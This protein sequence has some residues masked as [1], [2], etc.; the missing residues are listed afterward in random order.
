MDDNSTSVTPVFDPILMEVVRSA[1]YSVADEMVAALV[2]TAYST[3]IKDRRD[4]SAAVYTPSGAVIAQSEV[5]TPLHL[6][7][8]SA[9]VDTVLQTLSIDPDGSTP[10]GG[11]QPGDDVM[12]NIPYPAGPG[13]LND[14]TV[15]SPVFYQNRIVALVANMSHHVDVGGFAPGSMPVGVHE[16]YQEGLQ[17]PPVKIVKQDTVDQELMAFFLANIRTRTEG[18]GDLMA[19]IAA[20]NVG[21]RRLQELFQRYDSQTLHSAMQAIIDYSERRMR[22]GIREIPDG[23]YSFEDYLEFNDAEESLIPIRV[24]ITVKDD[25]VTMDFTG[26]SPQVRGSLNCR[27]PTVQACAYY[28]IKCLV[29]P[30][31]PPNSGAHRPIKVIVPEGSLLH[32][33]FPASIVHSNI[34][35]TQRIVDVITGALLEAVPERLTAACSGTENMVIIGGLNPRTGRWF[36]YTETYGGGQGAFYDR[37]GM[38]GV[39]THMTNTRNAPVEVIEASYPITVQRYGLVIDSEGAGRYRGGLGMER[40]ITVHTDATLTISSDRHRTRPWGVD[41]GLPAANSQVRIIKT[42]T[43]SNGEAP[44]EIELPGKITCDIG[45]GD[46]LITITPGGGGWGKPTRRPRETVEHDLHERMISPQRAKTVYGLGKDE[47]ER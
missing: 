37:D 6:G 24:T 2:R 17:I 35:T 11:W 47:P 22:A 36:N 19:Q 16:I 27:R 1:L 12:M 8:M 23:V 31:L 3:N 15:V 4:C 10:N 5:A 44:Q 18:R 20:N 7:V 45:A 39:H 29:D 46:E 43:G 28:V 21:E 38:S 30:G 33:R 34:V 26:T 25:E 32:A 13:H 14:I 41:G 40:H 42:D 9:V